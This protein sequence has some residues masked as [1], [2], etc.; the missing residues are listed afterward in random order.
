LRLDQT[1]LTSAHNKTLQDLSTL[2]SNLENSI[3]DSQ[4]VITTLGERLDEIDKKLKALGQMI[5]V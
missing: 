3:K 1:S 5:N 4:I 2:I